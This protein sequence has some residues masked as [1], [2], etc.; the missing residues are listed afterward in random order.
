MLN[1]YYIFRIK[2]ALGVPLELGECFRYAFLVVYLGFLWNLR[3]RCVSL[4]DEKRLK[5]IP[6]LDSFL[7]RATSG[8]VCRKETMSI[9]GTLSHV[10]FVYRDGRI[11][12]VC[13]FAF[14]SDFPDQYR[15]P[16]TLHAPALV[17]ECAASYN[18]HTFAC[19][20]FCPTR[21]GDLGRC[22]HRLGDWLNHSRQMG[23]L[24]T[25]TRLERQK[26]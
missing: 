7:Q 14:I 12:L 11:F 8:A 22:I 16:D 23:C 15:P 24:E 26:T 20:S 13:L 2:T 5:Y 17:T 4:S 21:P 25:H 3:E 9:T 1:A 6:K 19:T 18:V 10:A